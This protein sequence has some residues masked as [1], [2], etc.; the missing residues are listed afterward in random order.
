MELKRDMER[1]RI[2]VWVMWEGVRLLVERWVRRVVAIVVN[3]VVG[4]VGVADVDGVVD[5]WTGW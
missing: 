5:D 2:V 1:R 4:D 3:W